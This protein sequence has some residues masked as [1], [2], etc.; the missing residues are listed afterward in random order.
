MQ[1][2][3]GSVCG[4][5]AS[6]VRS[7]SVLRWAALLQVCGDRHVILARAQDHRAGRADTCV[8]LPSRA[9]GRVRKILQRLQGGAF[10]A[11]CV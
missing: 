3:K 1:E 6:M 4:V 11:A 7:A 10:L 5:G 2:L 9:S 8:A